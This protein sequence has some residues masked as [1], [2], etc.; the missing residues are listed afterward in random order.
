MIRA[1]IANLGK[2]NENE[3]C[4][5][6]LKLPAEKKDVQDLLARI[7][8]DGVLYEEI[9]I[10]DFETDIDGLRKYLGEYESVDELNYLAALLSDMERCDIEKFEAAVAHGDYTGSVKHLINLTQNLDCFEFYGGVEDEED[11]GY[12]FIDE[13]GDLTIPENLKPYFNYE[14]Y[15]E[16]IY[17]CS[18]GVF[19]SGG[20]I[21]PNGSEFEEH[22]KG[23]DDLPKEYKIFFYPD[24]PSQMPI[25]QQLEMYSKM[26]NATSGQ[27]VPKLKEE[28]A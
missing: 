16:E 10:V 28:R 24:P 6:W 7:G 11:L 2:Y 8:V 14:L 3:Y 27:V 13:L 1:C 12:Y 17:N 19:V 9:I 21:E 15:G 5:E 25:A 18:S 22:Y 4:G 23:R 26:M 20:F